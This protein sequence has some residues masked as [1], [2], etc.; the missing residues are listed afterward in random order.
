MSGGVSNTLLAFG[1]PAEVKAE[2]RRLI[3]LLGQ[4]GGYIVDASAILQNDTRVENLR[5]TSEAAREFGQYRSE[6][7][8]SPA[9]LDVPASTPGLPEWATQGNPR[10]GVCFPFEEK[11]KGLPEICGDVAL[12]KRV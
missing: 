1:S 5:A 12:V 9:A 6:S 3:E 2:T 4:D 11:L 7:S 10:P 8:P